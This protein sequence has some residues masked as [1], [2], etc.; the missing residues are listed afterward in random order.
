MAKDIL[1]QPKIYSAPEEKK[2]FV[3]PKFLKVL[4]VIFILV[5]GLAYLLFFSP[6]FKIKNIEVVGTSENVQIS[7]ENFKDKNIFLVDTNQFVSEITAVNPQFLEVKVLRGIPNILRVIFKERNSE[8][9]WQ[10]KDNFY[11]VDSDGV[12]FKKV[13]KEQARS[14]PLIID[15]QGLDVKAPSD[16]SSPSFID[17]VKNLSNYA[18]D[19]LKISHFEINETIFQ[20]DAV[21]NKKIKIIFDTTRSIS[22]QK[23]AFEKIYSEHKNEIK[24]YIDV[25]VE[26]MVY[27]K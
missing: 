27:Y 24:E 1:R 19:D 3:F 9:V 13:A 7:L 8:V 23:E 26:G 10:S 12:A 16:V 17:F 14:Y 5:A 4:I 20:I 25:R 2:P 21:T 11:F 22:D 6:I 15:N 18:F